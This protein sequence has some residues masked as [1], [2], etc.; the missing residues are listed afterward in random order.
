MLKL[1][2]KEIDLIKSRI[3]FKAIITRN[4]FD[5]N[6]ITYNS[7]WTVAEGWIT[8]CNPNESAGMAILKHDYP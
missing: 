4:N 7:K 3:L 8:G 2:D 5:Y 1:L 6:F